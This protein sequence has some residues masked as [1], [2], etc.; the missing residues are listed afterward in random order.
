M[1]MGKVVVATD[2][3][4]SRDFLDSETG[5]PVRWVPWQT[6]RDDGA[7]G[8]GTIWA[9]VDEEH[10]AQTLLA[11]TALSDDERLGIGECAQRRIRDILSSN[12]V[13]TEMHA[14]IDS[15]LAL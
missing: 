4:G 3:G 8:K 10:L 2:F 9:K 5:F 15:L 13:S 1:A 6:S 12:A 11:A 14:S 7:Y